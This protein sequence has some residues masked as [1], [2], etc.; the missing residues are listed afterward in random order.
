MKI[1]EIISDETDRVAFPHIDNWIEDESPEYKTIVHLIREAIKADRINVAKHAQTK[2]ITVPSCDDHTPYWGACV[3]CG[4]YSVTDVII[5]SE[6]D[7]NS[8]INAPKLD[9]L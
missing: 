4:S 1:N 2:D 8:I 3:S 9:L 6:V 7:K 5:G